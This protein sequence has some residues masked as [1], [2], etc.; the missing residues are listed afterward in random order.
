MLNAVFKFNDGIITPFR[1]CQ[2]A[3]SRYSVLIQSIHD[4]K[5]VL[6]GMRMLKL[7]SALL[8]LHHQ[9]QTHQPSSS[10]SRNLHPLRLRPLHP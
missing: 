6:I 10:R 1:V 7:P 5:S 4:M 9:S 8:A 3:H 2:M